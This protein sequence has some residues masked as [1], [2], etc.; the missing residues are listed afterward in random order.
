MRR[1]L[2]RVSFLHSCLIFVILLP[3]SFAIV[4]VL[5][6]GFCVSGV[7]SFSLYVFFVYEFVFPLSDLCSFFG[8]GA[9]YVLMRLRLFGFSF[10]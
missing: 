6:V 10:W 7:V 5:S 2:A 3:L 9:I 8:N 4:V 1:L